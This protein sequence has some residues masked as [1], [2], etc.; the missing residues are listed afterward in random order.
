MMEN[1]EIALH[2]NWFYAIL[3]FDDFITLRCQTILSCIN[4]ILCNCV[5]Y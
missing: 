4:F 3:L 1:D 5:A 2:N